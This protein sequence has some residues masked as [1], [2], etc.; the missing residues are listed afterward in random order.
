MRRS[1]RN[2]AQFEPALPSFDTRSDSEEESLHD[3]GGLVGPATVNGCLRY[4]RFGTD[5]FNGDCAKAVLL[6]VLEDG[7]DDHSFN[8]FRAKAFHRPSI[9]LD[10][11]RHPHSRAP[12]KI[13]GVKGPQ[14]LGY[15]TMRSFKN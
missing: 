12:R 9:L 15:D 14:L 3:H 1:M 5:G 6:E 11:L 10:T 2:P 4:T 13:A 8:F 7:V